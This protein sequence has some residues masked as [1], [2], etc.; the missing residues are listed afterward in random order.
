MQ[1]PFFVSYCSFFIV[2]CTARP[3]RTMK[4]EQLATNNRGDPGGQG[5]R[6]LPVVATVTNS[7][8]Q[9]DNHPVA[10]LFA[11]HAFRDDEDVFDRP[12]DG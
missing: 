8:R 12:A 7:Q 10:D 5:W 11:W 4:N 9:V 3:K 1:A 6:I 2:R